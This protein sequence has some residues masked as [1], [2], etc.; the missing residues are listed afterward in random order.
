MS[1][2]V[3]PR[4][5]SKEL[6]D[7]PDFPVDLLEPYLEDLALVNRL[8]GNSRLLA[9]YLE[10]N[11]DGLGA[12]SFTVLDI[13]A[14]TGEVSADLKR[15]LERHGRRAR[16]IAL[17]LKWRHLAV[18]RARDGGLAAC[19]G[20]AFQLPFADSSA[21]W[22]VSTLIL[23]HFSPEEN[24]RLIRECSRVARIGFAL[25]DIRRHRLPLAFFSVAGRLGLG[26]REALDDGIASV[27]QSYTVKEARGIAGRAVPGARVKRV[28]PYRILIF[29]PPAVHSA[30]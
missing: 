17:D 24:V 23:H 27:R 15:R 12:R 19:A 26:T 25:I 7:D 30:R 16:V 2:F 18:G 21:D 1:F 8:W 4:Q 28:F 13:G 6:L 29:K 22:V 14:G 11:L 20:N 5:P 10:R 9:G 3:P